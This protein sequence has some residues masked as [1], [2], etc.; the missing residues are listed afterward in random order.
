MP[1]LPLDPR[2]HGTAK[3]ICDGATLIIFS[4]QVLEALEGLFERCPLVRFS[5]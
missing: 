4:E 1:G 5:K 2:N 3:L